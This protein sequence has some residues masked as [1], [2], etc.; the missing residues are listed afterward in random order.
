MT[1]AKGTSANY[2]SLESG[3]LEIEGSPLLTVSFFERVKSAA[4]LFVTVY[5]GAALFYLLYLQIALVVLESLSASVVQLE[6]APQEG[7]SEP[8]AC[9]ILYRGVVV[10][11][12]AVLV[13]VALHLILYY[14]LGLSFIGPLA[15]AGL[16]PTKP[17]FL[18]AQSWLFSRAWRW[19]EILL[20]PL[21]LQ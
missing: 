9:T 11:I 20:R 18:L 12:G 4:R 5:L 19:E 13:I 14:G 3:V 10:A 8:D 15:G 6:G 1:R 2:E 21:Y 7:D 16:Q 17:R